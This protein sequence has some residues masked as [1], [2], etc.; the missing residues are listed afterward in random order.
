MIEDINH[1]RRHFM[2]EKSTF[3]CLA[4]DGLKIQGRSWRDNSNSPRA[5]LLIIHGM[6]EF[7]LR[8]DDF[9]S[10]LSE[11]GILVYAFDLRGHGLTTPDAQNRG[12][13]AEK[14]GVDLLMSDIDC[15]RSK[16][17]E[18]R[19]EI[20]A[21]DLPFFMF[22]HSMGSFIT[23][24]YIKRNH[25]KGLSG[26]ILSG[27]TAKAGL[28]GAGK[29]MARIQCLFKGPKSEGKFLDKVAFGTY[30]E[31]FQPQRTE[32]DWL[33]RDNA[34]VDAYIADPACMFLFKASGFSDLS[35]LLMECGSKNWTEAVPK[36]MPVYIYCGGNDPVGMYSKGP[37]SLYEWY[38]ETGHT[39]VSLKVYPEGRHEMHNELN[40]DEVYRAVLA[41]LLQ[42]V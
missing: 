17:D 31:K 40:R 37:T 9:A 23:S 34:I 21:Q 41:F 39:D 1:M 24:C 26:V 3:T 6:T 35:S 12:F 25:A 13:F 5:C 8:Y 32:K 4:A 36:D 16:I 14:N 22:G 20:S 7:C 2:L 38:K 18:L 30:N 42:H 29:F 19:V 27:T 15:V 11:Q 10:F 28:A 33:T